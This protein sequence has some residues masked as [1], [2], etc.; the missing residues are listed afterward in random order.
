LTDREGDSGLPQDSCPNLRRSP[1][2]CNPD[3]G[4]GRSDRAM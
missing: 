3:D 1:E 4:I 2:L